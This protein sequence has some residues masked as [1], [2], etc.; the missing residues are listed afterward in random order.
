MFLV[1]FGLEAGESADFQSH[2]LDRLW[3]KCKNVIIYYYPHDQGKDEISVIE[4]IVAEFT[5]SDE[6]SFSYRY[7]YGRD[8]SGVELKEG[9]INLERLKKTMDGIHTFFDCIGTDLVE[10]SQLPSSIT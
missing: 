6:N 7:A 9:S 1:D 8:G 10:R 3:T 4:A 5:T 2:R